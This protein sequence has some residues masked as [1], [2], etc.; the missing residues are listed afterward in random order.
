MREEK[1]CR[2]TI[3][4][5]EEGKKMQELPVVLEGGKLQFSM[6]RLVPA[7]LDAPK[8]GWEEPRAGGWCRWS[9]KAASFPVLVAARTKKKGRFCIRE[10]G[11]KES[12]R[13]GQPAA[14]RKFIIRTRITD[15]VH[16]NQRLR[17]DDQIGP[18]T[19]PTMMFLF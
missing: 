18:Q 6:D 16:G 7:L 14:S 19:G 15:D 12:S 10:F 4:M 13:V 9:W 11:E 8:P 5:R 2:L 17:S 1:K 3:R